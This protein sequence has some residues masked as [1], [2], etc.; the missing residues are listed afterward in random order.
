[1]AA[2]RYGNRR[3]RYGDSPHI[4]LYA[5]LR[6][7]LCRIGKLSAKPA[8]LDILN[9][10]CADGLAEHHFDYRAVGGLDY[11]YVRDFRL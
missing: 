9:V 2:P 1:M 10:A 5:S 6:T 4:I 7:G 11:R 8:D 3:I